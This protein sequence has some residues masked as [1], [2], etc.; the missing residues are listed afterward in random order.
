MENKSG[1]NIDFKGQNINVDISSIEIDGIDK[2]DYPD[3]SDAFISYA[4]NREGHE[5][6][7]EQ[8]EFLNDEHYDIVSE[9]IFDRQ[10][11]L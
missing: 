2:R 10:L 4:E 3:F 6:S 5:L 9:L 7:D 11:Y 8:L 1:F